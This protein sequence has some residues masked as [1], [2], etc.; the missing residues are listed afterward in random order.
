MR[1]IRSLKKDCERI[2]TFYTNKLQKAKEKSDNM[3]RALKRGEEPS[4][5]SSS[6]AASNKD[7]TDKL[8]ARIRELERQVQST[9]TTMTESAQLHEQPQPADEEL[10]WTSKKPV[11]LVTR[12]A[13]V[14]TDVERSDTP[15]VAPPQVPPTA[16]SDDSRAQHL[17][18]L[19]NAAEA[20]RT[21]YVIPA[22]DC[23]GKHVP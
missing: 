3:M 8:L 19:L 5:P 7:M 18:A 17:Q 20:E 16:R 15:S 10:W 9:R 12:E 6:S 14:Q 1:Q 11:I 21:R 2:R 4:L 13:Q 23:C 22:H